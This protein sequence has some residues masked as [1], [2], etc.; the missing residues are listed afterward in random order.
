MRPYG[1]VY[2]IRCT[3]NQKGYVG[4]TVQEVVRRWGQHRKGGCP[5]L[6]AAVAK[7]GAESFEVTVLDVAVDQDDLN[8][9]EVEWISTLGTL[10]PH[11]Y[12]LKRGGDGGGS[13]SDQARLNMRMAQVGK[14]QSTEVVEKRIAPLRGKKRPEVSLKLQKAWQSRERK[15]PAPLREKLSLAHQGHKASDETRQKMIEAQKVRRDR[16]ASLG[17]KPQFSQE[18][19]EALRVARTGTKLS[20]ETKQK[21]RKSHQARFEKLRSSVVP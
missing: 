15:M 10:V 8:R 18:G 11:G 7:Y 2:L 3:T 9:K 21:M 17:V 19:R 1:H 13:A 12:N 14:K 6:R 4:Q 5:A 16:E 20:E